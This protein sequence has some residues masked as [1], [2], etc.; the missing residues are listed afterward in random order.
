MAEEI[1]FFLRTALYAAVIAV[2]YWFA[3]REYEGIVLGYDWAGTTLL[4][5]TV[6]ACAA[7]TG[8][9]LLLLRSARHGW[10]VGDGPLPRRIRATLNRLVGFGEVAG[11]PE[12]PLAGGPDLFPAASPW[13]IVSAVAGTLILLGL[14][15]GA[16]LILPGVLLLAIGAGG[17][18]RG[19]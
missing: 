13:P 10:T 15:Y 4:A 8:G 2:V 11:R 5:F 1:R 9:V 19:Q 14:V 7:M 3:S 12:A 16:W 6:L 17:W 18:L